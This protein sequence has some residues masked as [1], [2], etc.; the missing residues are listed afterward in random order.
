M[1]HII[2][3]LIIGFIAYVKI[4]CVM[5]ITYKN[6]ESFFARK[7]Y[8]CLILEGNKTIYVPIMWTIIKEK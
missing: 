1:K 8:Y 4:P 7:S 2:L 5:P 6:V 3:S